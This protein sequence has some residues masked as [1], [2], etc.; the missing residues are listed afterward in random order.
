MKTLT[1]IDAIRVARSLSDRDDAYMDRHKFILKLV[2][3]YK[4]KK[5]LQYP[6]ANEISHASLCAEFMKG[7]GGK[8]FEV[9]DVNMGIYQPTREKCNFLNINMYA[10]PKPVQLK[11]LLINDNDFG[12]LDLQDRYSGFLNAAENPPVIGYGSWLSDCWQ[13]FIVAKELLHL[14]SGTY[15]DD[16]DGINAKSIIDFARV[17]RNLS[18]VNKNDKIDDETVGLILAFEVLL[19]WRL[20][21]QLEW[22][23]SKKATRLSIAR[24]FMIP[25][26]I[27]DLF[28]DAKCVGGQT[29]LAL[30]REINMASV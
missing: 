18:K 4:N 29:Y 24:T 1:F 19:P 27:I 10:I 7:N 12:I 23:K 6:L 9:V 22:L 14:Y 5:S 8:G 16:D 3:Y 17:S 13:R 28:M 25:K 15:Y 2:E 21:D 30:S 11:P 26:D 20:R